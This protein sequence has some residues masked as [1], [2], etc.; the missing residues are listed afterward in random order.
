MNFIES[1]IIEHDGIT[2]KQ[3]HIVTGWYI[4]KEGRIL[5][6]HKDG[7]YSFISGTK[8]Y[9]KNKYPLSVQVCIFRSGCTSK[10]VNIGKLVLDAY[11]VKQTL[12]AN[13]KLRTEVDHIDRNPFNNNIDNLRW[14]TRHENMLNR[15]FDKCRGFKW[16]TDGYIDRHLKAGDDLPLGFRYGRSFRK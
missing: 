13:G 5:S 9:N 7:T 6:L 12:D 16:I 2:Y 1:N 11:D 10:V 4:S 14:A 15:N 3:S 8:A